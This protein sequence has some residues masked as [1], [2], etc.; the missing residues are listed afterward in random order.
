M[1][2][3][4]AIYDYIAEDSTPPFQTH[5]PV[6]KISPHTK[7]VS[8]GGPNTFASSFHAKHKQGITRSKQCP[9]NPSKMGIYD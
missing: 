8:R 4:R 9:E 5:P 3:H 6:E 7:V 2:C 1:E